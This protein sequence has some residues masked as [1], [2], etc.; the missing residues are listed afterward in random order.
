MSIWLWSN[1]F[2]YIW[3]NEKSFIQIWV[4]LKTFTY[5]VDIWVKSISQIKFGNL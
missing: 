5:I 3:A 2:N 4:K 1:H